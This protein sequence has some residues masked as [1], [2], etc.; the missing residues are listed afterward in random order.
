M[1]SSGSLAAGFVNNYVTAEITYST[2]RAHLEAPAGSRVVCCTYLWTHLKSRGLLPLHHCVSGVSQDEKA[3]ARPLCQPGEA[4]LCEVTPWLHE[5]NKHAGGSCS[6]AASFSLSPWAVPSLGPVS[7]VHSGTQRG[8]RCCEQ[9]Q[10][11]TTVPQFCE[12]HECRTATSDSL[13]PHRLYSPWNSPGQNSGVRSLSP[14]Q[15]I[16]PTQGLNPGLPHWRQITS[17]VTRETQEYW[18]G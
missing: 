2:A 6:S 9:D 15:G 4:V 16:F 14:L 11:H 5:E 8:D 10:Q 17:W 3:V 7:S 18:S 13:R 12:N 1:A